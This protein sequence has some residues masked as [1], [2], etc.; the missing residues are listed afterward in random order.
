METAQMIRPASML[1]IILFSL[2]TA[3]LYALSDPICYYVSTTGNDSNPGTES[4]PWKTLAKAASMA[5]ANV[6]VFIKKGTYNERLVPLNSGTANAPVTFTSYPG[7]SASIDG[8]GMTDPALSTGLIFVDGLRYI[9]ISGLQIRHSAGV[10]IQVKN[11]SH[12]TI[13]ENTIDSTYDM[14]LKVHACD[15]IL[16]EGNEIVRACLVNDLEECLSV[17]TTNVIEISTNRVHDGRAIGIDVKYGSSNVILKNNEVYNQNG[18]IGIYVEA[19]TMHQFN[20]DVF[21]NISHDNQIGFAVTSEMGGLNEGIKVHHN[22]AYH[23]GQR[24]FWVGGWGGGETHPVKNIKIYG[25]VSY[26]NGFGVEIGGYA[27]TTMDSIEVNNNLIHHNTGAGVRITRYDGPSGAYVMRNVSITNN[28][29]F[30]NGKVGAAW[31]PDNAGIN[32]FNINPEN[33][34]IRNNIVSGN[35]TCTIFVAPEVPSGGVTIDYNFFG[36]FRNVAYETAGTNPVYGNPLFIDSLNNNYRLENS[37]PCVDGGHPDPMYNDPADP[38]RPGYAL[39][40]A[41]G[42]VRNDMGAYGGPHA[43]CLDA[44]TSVD[45]EKSDNST[46]S[47][48]YSLHQNYPNPFNPSTT[49]CFQVTKPSKVSLVVFDMMGREVERLVD[50]NPGPGEYKAV[51]DGKDLPSGVYFYRLQGEGFSQTRK[52]TLLK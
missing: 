47:L 3:G 48:I 5:T 19:W 25:N 42:T 39:F 1:I 32:L 31:D 2:S 35:A 6:T 50:G 20:I 26:E 28:T 16:V 22:I 15:N 11:S 12:I 34:V 38:T 33:L 13:R 21:D 45:D 14:G 7:D 51:F 29:I 27:G 10:G 24:G 43:T 4:L 41:L 40:P 8:E 37:S 17:S 9:T 23:N 46:R 30:G 18:C 49:I 52:L 44:V 36:G